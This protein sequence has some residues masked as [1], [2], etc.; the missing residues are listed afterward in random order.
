[1]TSRRLVVVDNDEAVLQ[2]LL[3][4]FGFEGHDIIATATDGEG[5]LRACAEHHPDVLVVDLRL[6]AGI[7]GLDVA[8]KLQGGGIRVVLYTNYVTP[9][10]VHAAE[11]A[12]AAVIEKG[13]LSALRRA[14]AATASA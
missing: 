3:L 13:N 12:G 5:G 8:R 10:V 6:G 9:T 14:V 4:D 7:D 11:F 1:M 2:L